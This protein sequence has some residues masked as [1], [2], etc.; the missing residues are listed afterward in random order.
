MGFTD[1]FY[2]EMLTNLIFF[3]SRNTFH[4]I[5]YLKQALLRLKIMSFYNFFLCGQPYRF[6]DISQTSELKSIIAS[7]WFIHFD[8][9]CNYLHSFQKQPATNFFKNNCCFAVQERAGDYINKSTENRTWLLYQIPFKA[10]FNADFA[11]AKLYLVIISRSSGSGNSSSCSRTGGGSSSG[12]D[13]TSGCGSSIKILTWAGKYKWGAIASATFGKCNLGNRAGKCKVSVRFGKIK[14]RA[15]AGKYKF[16]P[17]PVNTNWG[18]EPVNTNWCPRPV[19]TNSGPEAKQR[20]GGLVA[21]CW[22]C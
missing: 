16:E 15:R 5:C 10:W 20:V 11:A 9:L 6:R 12:S 1:F 8:R 7:T 4:W 19:K 18:P 2:K 13:S 14:L 17:G 3:S 22:K 21:Y